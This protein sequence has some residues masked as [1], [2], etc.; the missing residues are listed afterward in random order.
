MEK[1]PYPINWAIVCMNKREGTFRIRT[2]SNLNK[3]LLSKW[4]RDLRERESL[5]ERR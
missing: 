5:F 3:V 4:F 2:Q 1:K